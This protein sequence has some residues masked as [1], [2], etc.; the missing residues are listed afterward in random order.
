MTLINCPECKN[1]IS[2][3]ASFCVHCGYPLHTNMTQESFEVVIQELHNKHSEARS[4]MQKT[5]IMLTLNEAAQETGL[6]YD[7]L[8]KMCMNDELVHIRS[9]RK[10]LVNRLKLIEY[11]NGTDNEKSHLKR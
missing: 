10:Y 1:M 5:P 11:L 8:R 2:E 3:Y 7:Y 6:S 9:G 4:M